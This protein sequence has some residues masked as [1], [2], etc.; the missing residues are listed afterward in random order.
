MVEG[1][2]ILTPWLLPSPA[3]IKALYPPEAR[4]CFFVKGA[5]DAYS[6]CWAARHR[7]TR[8]ALV[9]L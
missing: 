8:P 6:R 2:V 4:C 3:E 7:P 1:W 5:L 9:Q